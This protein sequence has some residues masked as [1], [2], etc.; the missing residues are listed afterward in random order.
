MKAASYIYVSKIKKYCDYPIMCEWENTV[1]G[2]K[3]PPTAKW[4]N[5]VLTTTS[6]V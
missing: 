2:I 4:E 3:S 6:P 1:P 5:N